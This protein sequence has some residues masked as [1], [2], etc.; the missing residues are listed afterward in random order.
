MEEVN[1][2]LNNEHS[3]G[4]GD[5]LCLLSALANVQKRVVL[6]VSNEHKTF[7]RLKQYARIFRIPLSKLEIKETSLQGNF[8]NT[9]WPVKLFT[10]Y[11]RPGFVNVNGQV[12]NTN[13]KEDKKCI[14]IVGFYDNKPENNNN[15][16]PWCKHRPIE[17]WA[18][19]FAWAKSMDFEVIT[20][21]RAGFNLENKIELLVKHCKAIIS[22]EG[23]MAHLSHMLNIPCFL[24][25]WTF[26]TA[27]TTLEKFHCDFVHMSSSVYIVRNDEELFGW[28]VNQF[29]HKIMELRQ[30][31]TN[32]KFLS[33]FPH[34]FTFAE[35]GIQG[36]VSVFD[37][38]GNVVLTAPPIFGDNV[39]S[40]FLIKNY[41]HRWQ[42]GPMQ[43][44]A[45]L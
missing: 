44:S 39:M 27:S 7:E 36:D 41:L 10:E 9:G 34:K 11:Y 17:Y 24:I 31:K 25:D 1:I 28:D 16:W 37:N 8:D 26:P 14:A 21:D 13:T 5:N 23:G 42:R 19:L 38:L 20:L 4:L 43:E 30:G 35:N 15:E 40:E 3:V 2:H 32:N 29:N 22:Y 6:N 18:R 12:L 33:R 45:K